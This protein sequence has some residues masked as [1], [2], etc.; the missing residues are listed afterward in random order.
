[1]TENALVVRLVSNVMA[2]IMAIL[3]QNQPLF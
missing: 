1:M 2:R 3:G